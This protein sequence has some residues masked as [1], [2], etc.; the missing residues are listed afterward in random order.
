MSMT[1]A[2]RMMDLPA[3]VSPVRMI[4][5]EPKRKSSLSIIAKFW[6][7]SSVSISYRLSEQ[8]NSRKSGIYNRGNDHEIDYLKDDTKNIAYKKLKQ[9]NGYCA[10]YN[11]SGN[12]NEQ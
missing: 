5:P 9:N 4:K 10:N 3:P 11:A 12:R 2:S 7:W 1:T 8:L 6:M